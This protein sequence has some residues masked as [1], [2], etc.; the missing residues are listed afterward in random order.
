MLLR[1]AI[2]ILVMLNLGAAGWWLFQPQPDAGAAPATA[3]PSL[4]LM[5]ETPP[6]LAAAVPPA[7]AA[8]ASPASAPPASATNSWTTKLA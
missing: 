1:A 4:R 5:R 8:T 2:V 6:A 3:A 7:A